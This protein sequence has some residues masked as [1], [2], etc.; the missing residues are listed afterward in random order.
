[1]HLG[2]SSRV[3]YHDNTLRPEARKSRADKGDWVE[4][5]PEEEL[6]MPQ[7][8]VVEHWDVVRLQVSAQRSKERK[9]NEAL[10]FRV[11]GLGFKVWVQGA[12]FKPPTQRQYC[13][14]GASRAGT[15]R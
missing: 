4:F 3:C 12:G 15:V 1:M 7:G 11:E 2:V 8:G 9:S 13:I 10:A 14:P 6:G 5:T